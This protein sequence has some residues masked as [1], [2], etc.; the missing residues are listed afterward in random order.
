MEMETVKYLQIL[1]EEI[2]SVVVATLN[3]EGRPETRVIDMMLYD[4]Q[5][6][7]FL[8]ARGKSFYHQLMQQGY[9]SLSGTKA[10]R[11]VRVDGKVRNIGHKK[12]AEI[13]VHNPYMGK[14]YPGDTC[15]VLEVFQLYEGTG[16]FFDISDPAHIER[17][18]FVIGKATDVATGYQVSKACIGCRRCLSVCPQACITMGE[19]DCTHIEDSHCLS[20]G[21]CAEVC[22]VQAI[23]R[24]ER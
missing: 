9:A 12:L 17:G 22:P 18:S 11:A 15:E 8:T 4:E 19:N 14:I 1:T 23:H 13:F 7:Y 20:C 6:L 21:R 5:G 24:P 2:H 16:E 10:K 3:E